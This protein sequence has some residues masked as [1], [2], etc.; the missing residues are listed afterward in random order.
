[1]PSLLLS[2]YKLAAFLACPRRF[3][4]RY[5]QQLPWPAVPQPEE[6]EERTTL[7]RQFHQ[8]LQRHFMGLA[9]DT[10]AIGNARLRRWWDLFRQNQPT[11][12][13]GRILTE[14]TLTIPIGQ[15]FLHGRFDLVVIGEEGERPFAHV[16]DW[17]TGKAQDEATLRRD[18]QTRLYLALLAEGG[19]ALWGEGTPPGLDPAAVRITYWYVAEPDRPRTL[20]YSEAEHRQNWQELTAVVGQIEAH[21][22]SG[23][24][25]LTDDLTQCRWCSYQIYC[26]RGEGETAAAEPDESEE[27]LLFPDVEP[28]LP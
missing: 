27:E 13:D 26:G 23:V 16:F 21:L 14:A 7:G 28:A 15:H 20:L 6:D 3:E 2:R 24:W 19:G 8:L 17:K 5:L 11:V 10:A 12:P 18:W 9:V 1:M 25:P 4:L 22:E